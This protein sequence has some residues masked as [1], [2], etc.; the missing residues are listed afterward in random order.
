MLN[1]IQHIGLVRG[2]YVIG[3]Q[4]SYRISSQNCIYHL[5]GVKKSRGKVS[6]VKQIIEITTID[7]LVRH[8]PKNTPVVI[9]IDGKSLIHKFIQEEVGDNG[10]NFVLPSANG[11][12]FYVQASAINDGTYI[13]VIR[14][15]VVS[16]VLEK[17]SRVK[18]IP[19]LIYFGPFVNSYTTFLYSEGVKLKTEFWDIAASTER[20]HY[21]PISN[22]DPS[23]VYMNGES[24]RS[25]CLPVYS[26]SVAYLADI[27]IPEIGISRAL[28]ED[29]QFKRAVW[30]GGWFFLS[31]VFA[32]L[33]IN[34]F[35]FSNYNDKFQNI[36]N[37]IQQNQSL[38]NRNDELKVQYTQKRRFIE[39]SGILETSRFS[40]YSDR[41]ARIVPDSLQLTSVRIAPVSDKIRS[42]KPI[43]FDDKII[44]VS[45]KC[46]NS[47]YFNS[48]KDDLKKES[49]V[50]TILI[51]QFG[52]E[53]SNKPIIFEIQLVIK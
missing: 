3:V 1:A 40:F 35:F 12:D 27:E 17:F 22:T 23:F 31:L 26:L 25:F 36:N 52:Q 8:I 7:E 42:D 47:R 53:A 2:N 34:F 9:C 13:S 38:L 4:V 50:E 21:T 10:L 11:D 43:V 20:V 18:V 45:G 15:E 51:N 33:L 48:W 44:I 29:F 39:R 14:R 28:K 24:I 16:D 41:I 46:S 37:L 30:L 32:I 49:W 5:I 19:A 6:V